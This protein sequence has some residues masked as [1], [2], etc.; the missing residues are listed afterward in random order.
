M[1]QAFVIYNSISLCVNMY[2]INNCFGLEC[3]LLTCFCLFYIN[4]RLTPIYAKLCLVCRF[5]VTVVPSFEVENLGKCVCMC[6]VITCSD[7]CFCLPCFK[8]LQKY[9]IVYCYS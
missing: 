3:A 7:F 5:R 2:H 4:V 6:L 8:Y 9:F 1:M